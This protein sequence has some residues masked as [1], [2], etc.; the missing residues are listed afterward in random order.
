MEFML[1]GRGAVGDGRA[2]FR[3]QAEGLDK[4]VVRWRYAI[5]SSTG[6]SVPMSQW[7]C[8][9]DQMLLLSCLFLAIDIPFVKPRLRV[10]LP[11]LNLDFCSCS[12]AASRNTAVR[13]L[14]SPTVQFLCDANGSNEVLL[15]QQHSTA[16]A[17]GS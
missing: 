10:L 12:A 15:P 3:I 7:E 17:L 13:G 4:N 11:S 2:S 16:S 5:L 9:W 1:G 6:E 8:D 14:G